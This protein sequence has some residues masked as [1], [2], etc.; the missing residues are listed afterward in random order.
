MVIF[1]IRLGAQETQLPVDSSGTLL[2]ITPEIARQ[3]ELFRGVEGFEEARL[4]LLPDS[5]FSLELSV[6]EEGK[7]MRR[8]KAMTVEDVIALRSAVSHVLMQGVRAPRRPTEPLKDA[9]DRSGRPGLLREVL[10]LSLGYYGFSVPLALKVE[11]LEPFV[12]LYLLTGA[13][14]YGIASSSTEDI[15]VSKPQASAFLYRSTRGIVQSTALYCLIAGETSTLRWSVPLGTIGSVLMGT[16][17]FSSAG[18]NNTTAGEIG[19]RGVVED[20]GIV[21]GIGTAYLVRPGDAFDTGPEDLRLLG[22]MTL[23]GSAIGYGAGSWLTSAVSYTGGDADIMQAASAI[24]GFVGF[25]LMDVLRTEGR[26]PYVTASLAGAI[27][28]LTVGATLCAGMH[29]SDDGGATVRLA[30]SAGAVFGL[31]AAYLISEE[32]HGRTQFL[33]LGTAGAL[34]GFSIALATAERETNPTGSGRSWNVRVEPMGLLSALR[35]SD[36]NRRALIVPM[37]TVNAAL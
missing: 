30:T 13:V 7:T 36:K 12:G 19:V 15:S 11:R 22:G 33:L 32:P 24:G 6:L 3:L 1:S 14:G 23:L 10:G 35:G 5:T 27:T 26:K 4:Y 31:G 17:A 21:L 34:T 20:N 2:S 29:Y 9:P 37:L 28:G 16:A 18:R 25:T 8:R